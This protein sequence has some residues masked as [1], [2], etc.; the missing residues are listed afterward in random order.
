MKLVR[1]IIRPV[2]LEAV[3]DALMEAGIRGMTIT[4]VK[5][6]GKQKGHTAVYRGAEYAINFLPKVQVDII[7]PDSQVSQVIDIVMKAARTGEVGD[8]KIFVTEVQE[9]YTIRTGE[10]ETG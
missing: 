3:K 9:E 7:L 4:E 8:G 6:C 2:K 10:K 1:A 5:G